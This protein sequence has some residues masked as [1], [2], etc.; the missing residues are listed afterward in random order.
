MGIEDQVADVITSG[1]FYFNHIIGLPKNIQNKP[2]SLIIKRWFLFDTLQQHKHIWVP[3]LRSDYMGFTAASRTS[4]MP[5]GQ[6]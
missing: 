2:S 6:R 4:G 3:N 5:A 1:D